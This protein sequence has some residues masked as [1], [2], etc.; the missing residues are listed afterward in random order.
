MREAAAAVC[1][2]WYRGRDFYRPAREIINPSH[3]GV[4]VVD[5][6]RAKAF[7][8]R[9]HYSHG[10]PAARIRIAL[11][12]KRPFEAEQ[13]AGVA[14]FSVPQNQHVIP[15]WTGLAPDEG[16]ELGRFILLQD[17]EANGE[18]WMLRRAFKELRRWKPRVKAVIAYSDPVPRQNAEGLEVKPGHVGTIYQAFNAKYLGRSS[19][20]TML[21]GPKG[22]TLARRSLSKV[23]LGE[24]SK[25]YVF[26]DLHA[27]GAPMKRIGESGEA[28]VDRVL[29]L[30]IFRRVR[31][32]GNHVFLWRIDG[33]RDHMPH[34]PYPK[35]IDDIKEAA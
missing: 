3:Y 1:Q 2:R 10:Y 33:E 26:H 21:V 31:H 5:Q 6:K 11:F 27:A 22:T 16:I 14:V 34:N 9:H 17:V 23:R 8:E 4:D 30:G 15:Y 29:K 7:V 13:L 25:D 12:R 28:Y 19:P 32:P 24:R 18:T 35:F 20:D